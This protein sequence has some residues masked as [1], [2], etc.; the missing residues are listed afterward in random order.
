MPSDGEILLRAR[1]LGKRYEV[2]RSPFL[3]LCG[4]L[5]GPKRRFVREFTVLRDIDMELRQGDCLGII[6][7]NGAGKSTLLS[8]LSGVRRPSS[9]TLE[10]RGRT[11]ALLELGFG[12]DP[13]LSGRENIVLEGMMR[14]MSRAEVKC[15]TPAIIAFADIGEHIE[16]PVKEYSSGMLLR[17]AFAVNAH[18][19]ARIRLVDEALAV[20]DIRFQQKCFRF[21]EEHRKHGALVLVSHDLNAVSTLCSRVMVLE[22]GTAVFSGPPKEAVEFYTHLLYGEP[23]AAAPGPGTAR[24]LRPV[25]EARNTGKHGTFTGALVT[26]DILRAGETLAVRARAELR[27]PCPDPIIGFFFTDRFGKRVFGNCMRPAGPLP[28]GGVE[29]SFDLKW[30]DVAPGDHTLTLGIG[31]GKDI[32]AQEL[33]CWAVDFHTVTGVKD[34]DIVHGVF[35]VPA[36]HFTCRRA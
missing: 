24:D 19:E 33:F 13:E 2:C 34:H 15:K 4:A 7:R 6:G 17:L 20:G 22:Q 31:S 21:L 10:R 9:G 8:L 12:F 18:Q 5:A 16:Q 28:A 30:P 27:R 1:G 25:P 3:R 36:E 35:N 32:M 14:G 23:P 11:A 29:F 26:P